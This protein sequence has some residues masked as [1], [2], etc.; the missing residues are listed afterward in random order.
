MVVVVARYVKT[1]LATDGTFLIWSMELP[2]KWGR[3]RKRPGRGDGEVGKRKMRL[4]EKTASFR[5]PPNEVGH[6]YA[7]GST[8][9][10][11]ISSTNLELLFAFLPV[12]P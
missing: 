11:Y 9:R 1:K 7:W 3:G 6:G 4:I 8:A 12:S 2:G 10:H 5:W